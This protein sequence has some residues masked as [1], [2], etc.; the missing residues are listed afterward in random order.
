MSGEARKIRLIMELR[1]SGITDTRVLSAIERV[2]REAFVP[3]PFL[4]QAYENTALP[5]GKGQTVSQPLVVALM[6][7]ALE[8]GER[9]K[10]LEI[11]TGSGYQAAVLAKLCRRVYTVERHK[12]LLVEAERRFRAL[13]VNNITAVFGDGMRGWPEQA[14]FDRILVTA[15]AAEIPRLLLD[16]LA[17]GG[18]MVLPIGAQGG[19]QEVLRIRKRDGKPEV[20]RL[21]PVRFVP[22]VAGLE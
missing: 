14:P 15:A 20:E 6:T 2:P 12:S 4:D 21:F 13:S 11:G 22:L 3:Q 10:V 19:D 9:M 16:Q 7:Q 17:D 5:I 18:A 1:R 8:V